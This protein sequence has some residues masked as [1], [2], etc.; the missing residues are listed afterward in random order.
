M[1]Q[2]KCRKVFKKKRKQN[3]NKD[4]EKEKR[5]NRERIYYNYTVGNTYIF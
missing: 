4:K 3:K 5:N 1:K 2:S